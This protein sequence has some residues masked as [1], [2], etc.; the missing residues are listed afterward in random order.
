MSGCCIS[1]CHQEKTEAPGQQERASGEKEAEEEDDTGCEGK[2]GTAKKKKKQQ[3][4]QWD[5]RIGM[6]SR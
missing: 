2:E 6:R 5:G 4:Q 3:Q 1:A